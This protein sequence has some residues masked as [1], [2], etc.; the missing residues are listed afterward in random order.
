MIEINTKKRVN[1]AIEKKI[2]TSMIVSTEYMQELYSVI[3]IE[4]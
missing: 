2:I 3:N 1:L 4:R